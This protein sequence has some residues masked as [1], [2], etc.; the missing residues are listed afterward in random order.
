MI[1]HILVDIHGVLTQGDEGQKF[2]L[3]LK[4]HYNIDPEEQFIFWR[5]YL[6]KLDK[7]K[8]TSEEYVKLFN[9]KFN[10]LLTPDKYY[11]LIVK[12]ITPNFKLL[13][14]IS[15]LSNKY[16]IIIVSDNLLD[17]ANKLTNTIQNNFEKYPKFYSYEYGLTKKDGLLS[18]VVEKLNV[19]PHNCLFID[20]NQKNIDVGNQLGINS[21]I[22]KNNQD[23]FI[24]IEK[25]L[26]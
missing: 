19:K 5:N 16:Q 24:Q 9:Q 14:Y 15:E 22:F 17:L 11:N 13:K 26:N 7:N 6:D 10:V 18:I 23:L 3:A 8:I 2:S 4:N 1:T 25:F 12:N 20:D 21:I